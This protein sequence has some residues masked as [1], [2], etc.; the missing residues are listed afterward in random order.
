MKKQSIRI[1]TG[2][3]LGAGL[4]SLALLRRASPHPGRDGCLASAAPPGPGCAGLPGMPCR[5]ERYPAGWQRGLPLHRL[6]EGLPGG[7]WHPAL[8]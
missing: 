4:A 2:L 6:P 5:A 8:H 1:I 7:G 3:A